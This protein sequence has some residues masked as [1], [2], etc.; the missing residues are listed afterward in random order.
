MD[1]K[2]QKPVPTA[3]VMAVKNVPPP[4]SRNTRSGGDGAFQISGLA[5][6][7]YSI[8]VQVPGDEYLDP[9]QWN[10]NPTTVTLASGQ[11]V[12]GVSVKLTAASIV[13]VQVRDAKNLIK[14]KTKDGRVPDLS[15]GVWGPSGLYYPARLSGSPAAAAEGENGP[16]YRYIV[17]V[18]RDM[19]LRLSIA[20]RDLKLGDAAGTA[21]PENAS[22]QAFQ[23]TSDD[24]IPRSF[25]FSVLGVLP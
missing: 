23:H 4:F 22:Q 24:A 8:C 25:S 20:S 16:S 5:A 18:P 19:P 6:G 7:K 21:L 14:Q 3:L 10:G 2:T 9:C 1:A 13:R 12:S 15:V 11:A 17:A